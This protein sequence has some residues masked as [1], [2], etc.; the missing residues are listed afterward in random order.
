MSE[1]NSEPS[2]SPDELL[3]REEFFKR[4]QAQT[5]ADLQSSSDEYDKAILALFGG[6]ADFVAGLHQGCVT[7][8]SRLVHARCGRAKAKSRSSKALLHR[9]RCRFSKSEEQSPSARAEVVNLL[10]RQRIAA[11]V[12]N[13]QNYDRVAFNGEK[14]SIAVLCAAVQ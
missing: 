3:K 7:C 12:M 8:S 14:A 4:H 6:G 11:A 13:M 10:V 9:W 2:P 1:A 5:W